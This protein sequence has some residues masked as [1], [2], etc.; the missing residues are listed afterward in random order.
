VLSKPKLSGAQGITRDEM[1]PRLFDLGPLTFHTYGLLLA[2]AYLV[3]VSL[4]AH[5]FERDG[6]ARTRAWDLGFVI[7]IS[8]ILGGKVIMVL[9]DLGAYVAQPSRLLSL[10]FWQAGGVFYGGLLGAMAGGAIYL[11]RY[12]DL[13]FWRLADSAA[14]TIAIGQAIGRI[15]CFAAGCDYGRPTEG[16]W[17]VTFT[18]EYAHATVGVPLGV[19]IHPTQIYESLMT[20]GLFVFLL[21]MLPRRSFHGQVFSMYLILYSVG[22]FGLEFLRGDVDRGFVFGEMLSTSQFIAIIIIPLALLAYFYQRKNS[23]GTETGLQPQRPGRSGPDGKSR[24]K[25]RTR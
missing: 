23:P 5:L 2:T 12:P 18:N 22:R 25:A 19:P 20:L 14:P 24:R 6:I 15:G 17:A 9:T 8:A 13:G 11:S 10:E 7:I 4:L 16:P 21:W 1:F 3:A